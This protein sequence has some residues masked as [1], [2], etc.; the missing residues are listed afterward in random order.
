MTWLFSNLRDVKIQKGI[1]PLECLHL[2]PK[3]A[4][5][6]IY[7]LKITQKFVVFETVRILESV[8]DKLKE[9]DLDEL[10]SQMLSESSQKRNS[11][12]KVQN[13]FG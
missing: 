4:N 10:R 8:D 12:M 3:Q 2:C 6:Q 9:M 5:I 13:D 1:K 11:D 7:K